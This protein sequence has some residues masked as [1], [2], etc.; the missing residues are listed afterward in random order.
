MALADHR[1]NLEER[2]EFVRF[3]ANYMKRTTNEN[4]ST[5]QALLINSVM[6]SA[7]SDPEL[8]MKVKRLVAKADK[9]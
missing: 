9:R 1:R 3:W 4:W 5:Q 7:D 8:Y 6:K 2:L